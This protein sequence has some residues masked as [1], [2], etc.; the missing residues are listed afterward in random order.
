M[1]G[2]LSFC[3][4][5]K[6]CWLC[7]GSHGVKQGHGTNDELKETIHFGPEEGM[8]TCSGLIS[9][10]FE[11]TVQRP[12]VNNKQLLDCLFDVFILDVF[13]GRL[14]KLHPGKLT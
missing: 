1:S 5:M 4:L 3:V 13:S 6:R 10:S 8:G 9:S 11:K 2:Q 14:V 7:F 12:I